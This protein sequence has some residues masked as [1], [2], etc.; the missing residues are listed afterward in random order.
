MMSSEN[1]TV[2]LTLKLLL[3]L[4][5]RRRVDCI[6]CGAM[7]VHPRRSLMQSLFVAHSHRKD[8]A[9]VE[10]KANEKPNS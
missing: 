2:I 7:Q 4:L 3:S 1:G 9:G 6:D 5:V 8:L 10:G